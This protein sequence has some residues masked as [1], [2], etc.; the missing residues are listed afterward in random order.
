MWAGSKRPG[1]FEGLS[2]FASCIPK[3]ESAIN[4]GSPKR[5]TGN[6]RCISE[7]DTAIN[8]CSLERL[9][10]FPARD[11]A[12][13]GCIRKRDTAINGRSFGRGIGINGLNLERLTAFDRVISKGGAGT[14]C[15][16]LTGT[17][18]H[19]YYFHAVTGR[20]SFER[21][22]ATDYCGLV[23]KLDA[24]INNGCVCK[25]DAANHG[26]CVCKTRRCY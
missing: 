12:I 8:G 11:I 10:V 18:S 24:G 23:C 19:D 16:E 4:G 21:D 2:A 5:N 3:R 7:R 17:T 9:T 20:H 15:R 13:D 22:T 6:T 14:R 26:G 1:G 25:R